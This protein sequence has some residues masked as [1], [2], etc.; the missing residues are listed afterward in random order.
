MCLNPRVERYCCWTINLVGLIAALKFTRVDTVD[1]FG[2]IGLGNIAYKLAIAASLFLGLVFVSGCAAGGDTGLYQRFQAEDPSIRIEAVIEA[3]ARGDLK[4]LPYLVDR[5]EDS[6]PDVR[7]F[8]FQALKEMTGKTMDWRYFD[9]PQRRAV[10]VSQWRQWLRRGRRN[11][12]PQSGD[13]GGE[14]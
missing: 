8:S 1:R 11:D 4:A 7:F 14:K 10:A 5:L 2:A 9:R 6:E 13:I 3:A 12:G